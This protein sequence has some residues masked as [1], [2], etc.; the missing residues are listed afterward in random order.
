MKILIA[1]DDP[2]VRA[3]VER[4]VRQL[5]HEALEVQGGLEALQAI[6]RYDPDL[7]ITDLR[8]PELDGFA[9]IDAIRNSAV[10]KNLPIVCLSSVNERDE[11]A[12]LTALGISDYVLKPM[13][14]VELADRLR[15]VIQ[16][17]ATWKLD[18]DGGSAAS[19]AKSVLVID[20]DP[21]F[22]RF[23]RTTL[24]PDYRIVQA[25]S[26]AEGLAAFGKLAP[27]PTVA[28]IAEGLDLLSD[29]KVAELL[30]LFSRQQGVLA[31]AVLL[32]SA[33]PGVTAEPATTFD[34]VIRRTRVGQEFLSDVQKWLPKSSAPA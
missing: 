24:A 20:P 17:S 29:Q 33:D 13:R 23:V 6:E 1:D 12:R 7:L 21:A 16:R 25:G 15:G 8:M 3:V 19:N 28:L 34:G 5:S 31:P 32:V 2:I 30:R 9:L 11:I 18:R 27:R 14:P 4:V 26:G 10:F 22:R